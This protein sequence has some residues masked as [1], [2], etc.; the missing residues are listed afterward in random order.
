MTDVIN[1]LSK[2]RKSDDLTFSNSLFPHFKC[3]FVEQGKVCLTLRVSNKFIRSVEF[4]V[5]DSDLSY[6]DIIN[7]QMKCFEL[8]NSDQLKSRFSKIA[9]DVQH[10]LK[11]KYKSGRKCNVFLG[12]KTAIAVYEH[13]VFD[14]QNLSHNL[15][16]FKESKVRQ[17][18][19]C[20][21]LL[22][23]LQQAQDV[24]F[25]LTHECSNLT[26]SENSLHK[27]CDSLGKEKDLLNKQKN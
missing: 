21:D 11:T 7:S 5:A 4:A 2:E 22:V 12:E 24:N 17:K 16:E 23:Q 6:T 8:N 13:E 10:L 19:R 18:K 14:V 27:K 3:S 9:Y 26:I 25:K 15:H 20:S 1:K